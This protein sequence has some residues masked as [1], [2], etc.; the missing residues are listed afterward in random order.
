MWNVS[1]RRIFSHASICIVHAYGNKIAL[2]SKYSALVAWLK[3][4]LTSMVECVHETKAQLHKC[5]QA[6]CADATDA[7]TNDTQMF[8][9]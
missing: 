4:W 3:H 8:R 1:Y 6:P 7:C 2:E 5:V 9:V